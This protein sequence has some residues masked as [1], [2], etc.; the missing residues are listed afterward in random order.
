MAAPKKTV[1]QSFA[2]G[3]SFL[4]SGAAFMAIAASLHLT[5]FYGVGAAFLA[6]GVIFMVRGTRMKSVGK[7]AEE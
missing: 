7:D 6:L 2:V 3:A 4:G 5:A 1:G